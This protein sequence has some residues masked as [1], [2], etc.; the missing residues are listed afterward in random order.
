MLKENYDLEGA[1]R[2]YVAL[3]EK[4]AYFEAHEVLEEVWHPLRKADHPLKNLAKGLINGA[5]AFEHLKRDREN[6]ALKARKVMRSFD[7]YKRLAA[8]DIEHIQLFQNAC[9]MIEI[10]K[11]R[12]SEVFD[13][14]VP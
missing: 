3:L 1:L 7:R 4:E 13:V 5:I 10:L 14:L 6:A 8:S 11:S 9:Q 12:H 2:E